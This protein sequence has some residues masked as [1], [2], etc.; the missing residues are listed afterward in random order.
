MKTK[1]FAI[2]AMAVCFVQPKVV[3]QDVAV[4]TLQHGESMTAYYGTNAFVEAVAAAEAGDLLTLSAG[5]FNATTITKPLKIQGA[6]YTLDPQNFK[7]RTAINGSV[8]INIPGGVSGLL[9]EGIWFVNSVNV[10]GNALNGYTF[11]K[12]RLNYLDLQ[13]ENSGGFIDQCRIANTL[14]FGAPTTQFFVSNSIVQYIFDSSYNSENTSTSNTFD[15]CVIIHQVENGV[16]A[17]FRNSL[18][19]NPSGSLD[20]GYYNNVMEKN[21]Y[22]ST[23]DSKNDELNTVF[24]YSDHGNNPNDYT[25][26]NY[27]S[28]FASGESRYY[29]DEYDYRLTDEAAATYLG[30]DGTQVGIYGGVTSFT[31]VPSNPQVTSKNISARS[32]A[33]GKLS[34]RI[35]VEAQQ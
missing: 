35:T 12:C 21:F 1:L 15:H 16:V 27:K 19:R 17:N 11:R 14:K 22:W 2:V 31:D 26:E 7:Y 23:Y 5:N 24:D 32:N 29:N 18:I 30:S 25:N 20:C 10:Q 13:Y 33:N 8:S 34:V 6:G 28:L 3:A 4:V 9:F